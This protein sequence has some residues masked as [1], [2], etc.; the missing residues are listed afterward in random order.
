MSVGEDST[1]LEQESMAFPGA[2]ANDPLA[3]RLARQQR[4]TRLLLYVLI[5]CS[6]GLVAKQTYASTTYFLLKNNK[7][8]RYLP[9]STLGKK[10]TGTEV[11]DPSSLYVPS[12]DYRLRGISQYDPD[13][14]FEAHVYCTEFAKD[15]HWEWWQQGEKARKHATKKKEQTNLK[16]SSSTEH[17]NK[18]T[19]KR[20][21]IGVFAGYDDYAKLLEQ[22]V[23]SAR[24]YGQVWG[25]NVTVVT[26]QGTSFAPHGCKPTDDSQTT[27]NKIRLLF[28]AIDNADKYDQL[29]LLDA[30]A[31][32]YDMD[33]DLTSLLDEEKHV[34][35]AQPLRTAHSRDLWNVH[36]GVTLWNL[37]HPY[38]AS[39]AVDWFER[40]K[41]AV[42]YGTYTNDQ[43]YL[44]ETLM[45]HLGWQHQYEPGHRHDDSDAMDSCIVLNFERHEFD[46]D[47]GT[48]VKQ[49]VKD[50]FLQSGEIVTNT[51]GAFIDER[52]QRME[53]AA[54]NICSKHS[55]DCAAVT[56][57]QYVTF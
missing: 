43:E 44:Q 52:L 12:L 2:A 55:D 27:L 36:S 18:S 21:M 24:V 54:K 8:S 17:G 14:D 11:I 46:F 48:I 30:D 26:L 37:K 16:G 50:I 23:W 1:D 7:S 3:T 56:L 57:P 34:V 19:S 45:E 33:V 35:A 49:F 51:T 29:L 32:I 5:V 39:V 13:S 9:E 42:V 6:T 31:L 22:A 40:A 20:L 10:D 15:L 28:H 41:K 4:H 53:D 25:Q 47:H 38:V